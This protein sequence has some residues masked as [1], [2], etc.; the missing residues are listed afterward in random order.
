MCCIVTERERGNCYSHPEHISIWNQWCLDLLS[1]QQPSDTSATCTCL[2]IYSSSD[3]NNSTNAKDTKH[4][5]WKHLKWFHSVGA[6]FLLTCLAWKG[7]GKKKKTQKTSQISPKRL[8]TRRR[9]LFPADLMKRFYEFFSH[10]SHVT[11]RMQSTS[12]WQRFSGLRDPGNDFIITVLYSSVP[13]QF[14]IYVY[15]EWKITDC[16][17][18]VFFFMCNLYPCL[19]TWKVD[20]AV[21][22]LSS[23]TVGYSTGH[24]RLL[25]LMQPSCCLPKNS[26]TTDQNPEFGSDGVK[27]KH[28]N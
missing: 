20:E 17:V 4:C 3:K 27:K 28:L 21:R 9:S 19:L 23:L 2:I 1:L 16:F 25:P 10:W 26:S 8:D 6:A 15:Y 11:W 12:P 14:I 18:V 5:I 22:F 24:W 13:Q 7:F